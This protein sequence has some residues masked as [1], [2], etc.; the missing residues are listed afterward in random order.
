M[1]DVLTSCAKAIFISIKGKFQ[2]PDESFV[3]LFIQLFIYNI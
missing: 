1:F 2:W 3:Y